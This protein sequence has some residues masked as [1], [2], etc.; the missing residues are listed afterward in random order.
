MTI[1]VPYAVL[2]AQHQVMR[3]A[4]QEIDQLLDA[5]RAGLTKLNW[6]GQD[7]AAYDVAQKNWDDAVLD[8]NNVLNQIAM[9]VGVA[10][11]NYMTTENSNR[12]LWQ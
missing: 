4:S 6:V 9:A 7:R 12:Q 11:D 5:L 1:N 2:E 8:M 10:R 3:K